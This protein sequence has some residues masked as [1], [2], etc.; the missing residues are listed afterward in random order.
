[1]RPSEKKRLPARTK[2]KNFDRTCR[3]ISKERSKRKSDRHQGI[4]KP[5]ELAADQY[6]GKN[7]ARRLIERENKSK[8][9]VKKAGKASSDERRTQTVWID[10]QERDRY[11]TDT[12]LFAKT[13]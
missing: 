1:M 6:A 10:Q 8:S 2:K 4:R 5:R 11:K 7:R 3:K 12:R 9:A 13:R